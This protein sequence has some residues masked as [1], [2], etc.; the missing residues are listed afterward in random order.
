MKK[1]TWPNL[2]KDFVKMWA[3]ENSEPDDDV[4]WEFFKDKINQIIKEERKE[5]IKELDHIINILEPR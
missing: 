1:D 5:I 4:V 3:E 2:L